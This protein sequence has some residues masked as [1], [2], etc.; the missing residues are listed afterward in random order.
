MNVKRKQHNITLLVAVHNPDGEVL[1][2]EKMNSGIMLNITWRRLVEIEG[3]F[4]ATYSIFQ[5]ENTGRL[6]HA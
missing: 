2:A 5:Y 3:R 1:T 4:G 6:L